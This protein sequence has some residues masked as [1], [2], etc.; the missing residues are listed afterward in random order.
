MDPIGDVDMWGG[1]LVFAAIVLGL[2]ICVAW[3]EMG[4][5]RI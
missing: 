5:R 3:G 4:R 1:V 2:L